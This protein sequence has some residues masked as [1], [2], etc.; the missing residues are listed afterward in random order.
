MK[1]KDITENLKKEHRDKSVPDVFSRVRKAP[2]NKL[3][4]GQSPLKAFDK[5]SAVR[6]LWV[7][8]ALFIVCVFT[9]S[10]FALMPETKKAEP[11]SY[12]RISIESDGKTT[13]YGFIVNDEKAVLCVLEKEGAEQP[14]LNLN[15]SAS[16]VKNAING[17]YH[18][19]NNDKI[20]ICAIN[21][22]SAQAYELAQLLKNAISETSQISA[23]TDI[24][25]SAN[26]AAVI[27]DLRAI[28]GVQE[29]C[30]VDYLIEKYIE[31]FA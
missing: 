20:S 18:A 7:A 29:S 16:D 15:L 22:D 10:V 25:I 4:D 23:D 1:N 17:V 28:C 8:L 14:L 21:V 27:D 30:D 9:L 6:V 11:S 26:D 31:M 2:I 5:T 12:A 3:L 24:S 13:V 19:K